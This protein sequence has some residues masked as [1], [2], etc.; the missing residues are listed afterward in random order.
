MSNVSSFKALD[1]DGNLIKISDFAGKYILVDFWAS[2]CVPCINGFPHLKELY[3]KYKDKGLAVIAISTDFK[4]DEQKWLNAI[5]KNDISEWIQILACKNE[6]EY[7]ICNLHGTL[8]SLIPHYIVIDKSGN[9]IKQ[10]RGF[11]DEIAKEQ[12]KLFESV[13]EKP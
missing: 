8:L 6:G 1:K 7:N 11:N 2:W 5:D 4:E 3:S 9:V 13:F 12:N 10:W